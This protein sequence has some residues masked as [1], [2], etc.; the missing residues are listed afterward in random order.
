MRIYEIIIKNY[1]NFKN[2]KINLVNFSLIIGENNVGK[3]NL[4]N[5]IKG[6]LNPNLP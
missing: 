2:F 6:N 3:T 5:A 1:K 4:V